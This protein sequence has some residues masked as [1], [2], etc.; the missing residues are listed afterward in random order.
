MKKV[1]NIVADNVVSST[2]T[3]YDCYGLSMN[4]EPVVKH[5]GKLPMT[6]IPT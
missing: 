4:S 5:L 2:T 3:C 6:L 1:T